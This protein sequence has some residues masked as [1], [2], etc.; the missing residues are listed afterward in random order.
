MLASEER[1]RLA[2]Y[3]SPDSINFN[4]LDDGTYIDINEGFTKIM[5]YT[6]EDVIGKTILT[7]NVWK[8]PKIESG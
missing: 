6:R 3:T 8:T 5:G 1:F 4:R 2:F 7:L